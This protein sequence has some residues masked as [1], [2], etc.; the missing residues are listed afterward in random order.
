MTE[1]N[2]TKKDGKGD[3]SPFSGCEGMMKMMNRCWGGKDGKIDFEKFYD[4]MKACCANMQNG[5]EGK[6]S[7]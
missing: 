4:K 1:Q 6:K 7:E 5:S 3:K 2:N